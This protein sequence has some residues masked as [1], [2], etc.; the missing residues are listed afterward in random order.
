MFSE[1][2]MP[3]A[4]DPFQLY[5]VDKRKEVALAYQ[6]LSSSKIN[7]I[8]AKQWEQ[9]DK[10]E[11]ENYANLSM[12]MEHRKSTK[13]RQKLNCNG[14]TNKKMQLKKGSKFS[15]GCT[16]GNDIENDMDTISKNPK[17]ISEEIE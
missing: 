8:L 13:C 9:L 1:D 3:C 6:H 2:K 14:M 16:T 4:L 10:K 15:S 5:C 11:R 7:S 17:S 12:T